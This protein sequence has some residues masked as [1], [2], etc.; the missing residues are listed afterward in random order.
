[1]KLCGLV[2]SFYI[3]VSVSDSYIGKPTQHL[4]RGA[5]CW[6]QSTRAGLPSPDEYQMQL[7]LTFFQSFYSVLMAL[8][9]PRHCQLRLLSLSQRQLYCSFVVNTVLFLFSF[10]C[11]FYFTNH[12]Y[13]LGFSQFKK[14][15][16]VQNTENNA[17]Q[18]F[19]FIILL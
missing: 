12:V 3:H 18:I 4:Y 16:S 7:L 13:N 5:V 9:L 6:Y 10:V 1:M 11:L 14:R 2:P 15:N 19:I 8:L 17:R